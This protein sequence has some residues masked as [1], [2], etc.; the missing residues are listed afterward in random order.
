MK[1]IILTYLLFCSYSVYGQ[2]VQ[3][4]NAPNGLIIRDKPSTESSRI[5]KR[6]FGERITI[7]QKTD[8]GISIKDDGKIIKGN[9]TLIKG[10]LKNPKGYVFGG[11]LS[12][13]AVNIGEQSENFYL[14]KL[15]PNAQKNY[16]Y[17]MIH[18]IENKPVS[19]YL[20][21]NKNENISEYAINDM[22]S[23]EDTNLFERKVNKLKNVISLIIVKINYNS[24]C[25]NH[26][27]NYYL[28]NKN[29]ELI[30]LPQI[31]NMH[32]DGPEPYETYIFPDE[33]GG[34]ENSIL[35][36]KVTPE[37]KEQSE[38]HE[39]LKKYIWNGIS[40]EE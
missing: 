13:K 34:K 22:E 37:L 2:N 32:C 9:W 33:K 27:S 25:S 17:N 7:I 16:W 30:E 23:Y 29:E 40:I 28:I 21:N 35:H 36:V 38:R 31:S 20:R 18:S 19:I 10:D 8:I 26:Y 24:C 6:M 39:V 3:F 5:G 11:Y 1:K 15:P 4:V 14:T 12:S